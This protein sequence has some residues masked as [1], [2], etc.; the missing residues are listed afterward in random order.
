MMMMRKMKVKRIQM[1][2]SI[3]EFRLIHLLSQ[4][5]RSCPDR[6]ANVPGPC[7]IFLLGANWNDLFATLCIDPCTLHISHLPNF[8]WLC[9]FL[10]LIRWKNSLVCLR[11]F[12]VSRSQLKSIGRKVGGGILGRMDSWRCGKKMQTNAEEQ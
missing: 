8:D 12:S 6:I 5:I 4:A 3:F 9:T 7:R 1:T 11:A 10:I 2:T